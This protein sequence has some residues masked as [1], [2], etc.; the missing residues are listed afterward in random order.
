MNLLLE[1]NNASGVMS[2]CTVLVNTVIPVKIFVLT[3]QKQGIFKGFVLE[4]SA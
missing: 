1:Q 4:N 2:L 3:R